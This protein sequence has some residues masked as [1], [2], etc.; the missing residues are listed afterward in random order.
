[1]GDNRW[2]HVR[3]ERARVTLKPCVVVHVY[4]PTAHLD[5]RRTQP[6]TKVFLTPKELVGE[7][8]KSERETDVSLLILCRYRYLGYRHRYR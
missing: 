4:P 2:P 6:P 5:R 1:M 8:E 7:R 3:M